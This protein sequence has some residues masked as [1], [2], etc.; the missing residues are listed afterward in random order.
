MFQNKYEKKK[1]NT[2]SH[3][4]QRPSGFFSSGNQVGLELVAG[5]VSRLLY[6]FKLRSPFSIYIYTRR[7]HV[8]LLYSYLHATTYHAC[9]REC[10]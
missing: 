2:L 8:F 1:K 6:L 10:I 4:E 3:K 5:W 7:T 9:C